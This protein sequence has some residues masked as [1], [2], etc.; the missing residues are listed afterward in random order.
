MCPHTTRY[1]CISRGEGLPAGGI[2]GILREIPFAI[3]SARSSSVSLFV[4]FARERG[5]ESE[6]ARERESERASRALMQTRAHNALDTHTHTRVERE[7]WD[8]STNNSSHTHT[9]DIV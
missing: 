9:R 3:R 2:Q 6:R 4:F 5:R 8:R 1:Y 7:G